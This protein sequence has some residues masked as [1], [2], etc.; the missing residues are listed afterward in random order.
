MAFWDTSAI[1]PLCVHQPV[2]GS[3]RHLLKDR[4]RLV[5][6]WGTSVE[7]RSALARL[8][9][10]KAVIGPGLAQAAARLSVL[11]RSWTEVLPTQRLRDVAEDLPDR[12]KVRA[13]HAFQLAAALVWCNG[14]PLKRPFICFDR[15]LGE[16]AAEVGFTV[17]GNRLLSTDRRGSRSSI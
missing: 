11:R 5:V 4:R 7:V 2:T 15:Q 9:R 8:S 10:E 17:I 1:V 12:Y 14:R 13:A 16:T 3:L 6:W